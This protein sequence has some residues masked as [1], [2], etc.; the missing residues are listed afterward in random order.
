MKRQDVEMMGLRPRQ[1]LVKGRC[2]GVGDAGRRV[3]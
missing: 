1:K 2:I 3:L